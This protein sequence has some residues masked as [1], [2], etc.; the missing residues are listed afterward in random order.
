MKHRLAGSIL[1]FLFMAFLSLAVILFGRGYRLDFKKKTLTGTGLLAATSDP[2]GASIFVNGRLASATN[3]TLNLEPDWYDVRI[4]KEGY[5]TWQKDVTVFE[6]LVTE[7]DAL[8]ILNSP[9]F[10][11][12]TKHGV[13]QVAFSKQLDRVVYTT[14][15]GISPGV[16]LLDLSGSSWLS[17]LQDTHDQLLWMILIMRIR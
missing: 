9:R 3:E 8:L 12:L 4:E 6:G 2:Q 1:I 15:D 10:T 16:W 5:S 7:V 17:L 13:S 11:P 14:R